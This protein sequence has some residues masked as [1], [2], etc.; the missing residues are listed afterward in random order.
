MLAY[1]RCASKKNNAQN[2]AFVDE[3]SR[4]HPVSLRI[5]LVGKLPT[6][7]TD[8]SVFKFPGQPDC[9]C[10]AYL[11]APFILHETILTDGDGGCCISWRGSN[12]CSESIVGGVIWLGKS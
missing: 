11:Y 6:R 10:N 8:G 2:A 5:F 1:R 3:V 4:T 9:F 7:C 12:I